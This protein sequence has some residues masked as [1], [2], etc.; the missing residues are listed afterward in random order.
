MSIIWGSP[1]TGIAQLFIELFFIT[2]ASIR[3]NTKYET[4]HIR[5]TFG[6][7]KL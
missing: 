7:K 3:V 2:L 1:F 6:G 4:F 5:F